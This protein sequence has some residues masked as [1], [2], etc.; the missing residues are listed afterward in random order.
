M[1]VSSE[2]GFGLALVITI[3]AVA[4]IAVAVYFVFQSN[5]QQDAPVDNQVTT[6]QQQEEDQ[7]EDTEAAEENGTFI[8]SGDSDFGPMLFDENGQAIYI[9]ELEESDM[10]E[11]Y[12]DCAVA[13]PP[14]LTDGK[15]IAAGDVKEDL[16][17]TTERTDGSTQVTYNGHPLYYYAHEAP[18]EVKC[19]NVA[20]H[21]GLWWVIQPNG[22]RAE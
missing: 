16:L 7:T 22:N 3:L 13:W 5:S 21:G 17:G 2:K 8:T 19:H 11:C 15:P 9:W 10:A 1:K 6:E 20:T 4:G 18:G 12:D 14:V